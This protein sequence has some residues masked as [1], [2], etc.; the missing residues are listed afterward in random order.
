MT[1]KKFLYCID[2]SFDP[3]KE[4]DKIEAGETA[5]DDYSNYEK[6]VLDIEISRR[7]DPFSA[8]ELQTRYKYYKEKKLQEYS[9]FIQDQYFTY[10][11]T[12][13]N[14]SSYNIDSDYFIFNDKDVSLSTTYVL[15]DGQL[16]VN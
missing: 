7:A 8:L 16:A 14:A 12:Y 6:E 15:Q 9:N 13:S 11:K 2:E 3:E 1:K 5:Y 4:V 10:S